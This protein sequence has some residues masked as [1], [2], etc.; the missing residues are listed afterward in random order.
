MNSN[1]NTV[2][3]SDQSPAPRP[4]LGRCF[5]RPDKSWWSV[6]R[7]YKHRVLLERRS[8]VGEGGQITILKTELVAPAWR[9]HTMPKTFKVGDRLIC[10]GEWVEITSL[11]KFGDQRFL[12]VTASWG[13]KESK[14]ENAIPFGDAQY[15]MNEGL[16]LPFED[17]VDPEPRVV[18]AK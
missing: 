17:E 12:G 18:P 14:H 15:L 5:S 10:N 11:L 9:E 7:E 13:F 8:F 2:S 3:K 16:R 6:I 1:T 4:L